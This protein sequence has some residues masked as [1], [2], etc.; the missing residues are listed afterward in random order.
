MNQDL[1]GFKLSI[2]ASV[3]VQSRCSQ[4]LQIAGTDQD[5]ALVKQVIKSNGQ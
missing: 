5:C 2:F 3:E 1:H 4:H